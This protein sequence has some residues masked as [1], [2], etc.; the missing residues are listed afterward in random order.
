[1]SRAPLDGS[2]PGKTISLRL[3][4]AHLAILDRLAKAR[5]MSRSQLVARL[6][7]RAERTEHP[8]GVERA[9]AAVP[10]VASSAPGAPLVVTTSGS[11]SV[12]TASTTAVVAC[13]HRHTTVI[14]GGLKRCRDCQGTRG[15]DGVWR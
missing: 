13:L 2:G 12:T 1:M 7:E 9:L 8:A 4:P 15:L 3:A 11:P 14:A 6:L 10:D 5:S